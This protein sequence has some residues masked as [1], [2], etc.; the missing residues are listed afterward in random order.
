[1][2]GL[3]NRVS[4]QQLHSMAIII[5]MTLENFTLRTFGLFPAEASER[6]LLA[7]LCLITWKKS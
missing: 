2:T 1:M 5:F 3:P 7:R 4:K 6:L